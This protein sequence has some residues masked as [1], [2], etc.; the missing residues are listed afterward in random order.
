VT[1]TSEDALKIADILEHEAHIG[2]MEQAEM[3]MG[4]RL[5]AIP[6]SFQRTY[7]AVP[8]PMTGLFPSPQKRTL[9]GSFL[10]GTK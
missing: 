4:H 8:E 5:L 7:I 2:E 1:F 6:D 9:K 10:T 3:P